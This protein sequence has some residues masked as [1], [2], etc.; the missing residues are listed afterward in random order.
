MPPMEWTTVGSRVVSSQR[1][2]EGRGGET[3]ARE[4]R[5]AKVNYKGFSKVRTRTALGSYGRSMP[6]SIRPSQGRCVSLISSNP[7]TRG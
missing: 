5:A 3:R 7:C 1:R 2:E 6:R 4:E